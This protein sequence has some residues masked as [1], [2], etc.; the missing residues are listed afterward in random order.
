[1]INIISSI[2]EVTTVWCYLITA[3]IHNNSNNK[4]IG[5]VLEHTVEHTASLV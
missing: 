4:I 3:I 1:M 5:M 2:A